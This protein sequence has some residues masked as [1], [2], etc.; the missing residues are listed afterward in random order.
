[1]RRQDA[2]MSDP[3]TAPAPATA[4]RHPR[5]RRL[6]GADDGALARAPAAPDGGPTEAWTFSGLGIEQA[7]SHLGRERPDLEA[8]E[9]WVLAT[10]GPPRSVEGGAVQRLGR[11]A[12]GGARGR[13]GEP[14]GHRRDAAG[15]GCGRPRPLG[16][17]RLRRAARAP[18]RAP[19]AA[20]RR[21]AAVAPR[22]RRPRRSRHL[23]RPAHQR[24]HG[25]ALPGPGPGGG[26]PV[27]ADPQGLRP[28]PGHERPVVLDG[29]HELQPTRHRRPPVPGGRTST[30]T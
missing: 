8:F 14:G 27:A 1:M 12:G 17:A 16:S 11:R 30:G 24:H 22:R 2:R 10:A 19:R 28:A 18:S 15:A 23:V 21:G 6:L 26:A 4:A 5:H 7:F 13:G 9:T 3:S 20:A 29:P 25:P